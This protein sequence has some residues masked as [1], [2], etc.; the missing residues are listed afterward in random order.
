[1]KKDINKN[2]GTLEYDKV[3]EKEIKTEVVREY[4]RVIRLILKSKLNEKNK[5]QVINT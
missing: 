5:K 1:M 4:K 3:K 2:L